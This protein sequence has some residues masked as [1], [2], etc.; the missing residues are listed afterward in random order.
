MPE[1]ATGTVTVV[2]GDSNFTKD[3]SKSTEIIVNGFAEGD[4]E[5]RVL[6][7]GD[8]KY[9]PQSKVEVITA[10][11]VEITMDNLWD[12]FEIT[13]ETGLLMNTSVKI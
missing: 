11:K 2:L 1:D 5:I 3:A 6:Y 7:S 4:N 12:Y 8:N 10:E 13:E 9:V